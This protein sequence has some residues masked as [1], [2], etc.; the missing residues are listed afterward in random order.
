MKQAF[1]AGKLAS[2][3]GRFP[4]LPESCELIGL[5]EAKTS[6]GWLLWYASARIERW[7]PDIEADFLDWEQIRVPNGTQ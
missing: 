3:L 4:K 7:S 2:Q 5:Q 1:L 6:A